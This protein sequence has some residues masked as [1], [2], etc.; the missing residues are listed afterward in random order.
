MSLEWRHRGDPAALWR[1]VQDL[2][3]PQAVLGV[4][5]GL[6]RAV[7]AEV[8]GQHPFSRL[9]RGRM[10][11]PATQNDV[12]ALVPGPDASAVFDL[13][14]HLRGSLAPVA[15]LVEATPMFGHRQ[16]HDLSGYK[17]GTGNPLGDVAWDAALVPEC[18]LRGGSIVLVHQ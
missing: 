10:S 7:G 2:R 6:V 16:G 15:H 11:M 3:M 14:Q 17:D 18:P 12:W 5:A 9:Q 13:A 4:G 1:A 8:A